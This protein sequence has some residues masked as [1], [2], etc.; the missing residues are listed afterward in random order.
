MPSAPGGPKTV[1][2]AHLFDYDGDAYGKR[3]CVEFV[4][5]IRAEEK[6]DSYDALRQRIEEDVRIAKDILAVKNPA[7]GA[8]LRALKPEH[9]RKPKHKPK[10]KRLPM[11]MTRS[12]LR[13]RFAACLA[14]AGV[15]TAIDQ[16]TK[17]LAWAT[18]PGQPP[19]EILPFLQFT[20]VL[21]KGAA[22]G[23]LADAGRWPYYFLTGLSIAVS[24]ALVIWLWRAH[25][26]NALLSWGLALV[27]GRARSET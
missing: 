7:G 8:D 12:A 3:V 22:F 16:L 27:L 1:L 9:K 17:Q 19:V 2:E 11:T 15:V 14:F 21:N 20:L 10:P 26:R 18:L 6:F 24:I 4:Q 25:P 5:K 13:G 23:L